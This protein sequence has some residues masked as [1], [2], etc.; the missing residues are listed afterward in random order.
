MTEKNTRIFYPTAAASFLS[1]WPCGSTIALGK[2]KENRQ[3]I[4]ILL[5]T[6]EAF[7][8][9]SYILAKSENVH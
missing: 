1:R 4:F 3:G 8:V 2:E 9:S 5:V 7:F 6:L